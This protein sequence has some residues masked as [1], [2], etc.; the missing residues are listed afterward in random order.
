MGLWLVP[1]AIK[2]HDHIDKVCKK[3][4]Y[5]IKDSYHMILSYEAIKGFYS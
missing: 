1:L 2:V 5:I 3:Q 4:C